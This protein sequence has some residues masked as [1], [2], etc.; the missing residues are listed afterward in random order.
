[1]TGEFDD[2]GNDSGDHAA[3]RS[4]YFEENTV[5]L[6]YKLS[7]KTRAAVT[8]RTWLAVNLRTIMQAR[9]GSWTGTLIAAAMSRASKNCWPTMSW[10]RFC[11]AQGSTGRASAT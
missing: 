8:K 4:V 5:G 6:M 2:A 9:R 11:A 7:R 3:P 1:M 10:R